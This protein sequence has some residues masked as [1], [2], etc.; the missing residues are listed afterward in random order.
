MLE[1]TQHTESSFVTLTYSDL[2]LPRL[3]NNSGTLIPRD[4]QLFLKRFRKA[5]KPAKIRFFACG[6]YGDE[7]GRPHYHLA[8]FGLPNCRVYRSTFRR[9][10]KGETCCDTCDLIRDSWGFGRIQ[11]DAFNTG[12]AQ[13]VAGYVTKKMTAPDDTRLNGRYPEFARMSNRPGIG[14]D[15][16]HELAA[17]LLKFNLDQTQSDVPVTLAHG[18]LTGGPREL[19]LG[20]YLRRYLRRLIG[21]DEKTPEEIT[22]LLEA[23]ML[24]LRESAFDASTSF[25]KAILDKF[26][27]DR[28]A[29]ESRQKIFKQRKHRL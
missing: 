25:K 22:K 20:R 28:S 26:E 15:A 8:V 29:F 4:L 13:Y 23:E 12:T 14:A 10:P 19:P 3:L 2:Y 1:S 11:V 5:M 7:S 16:M 9:T 21:K 24:P 18:N 27:G 17:Q 6:E